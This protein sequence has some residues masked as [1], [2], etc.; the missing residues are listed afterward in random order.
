LPDFARPIV[1]PLIY[2]LLLLDGLVHS[3]G[4]AIIL[5]TVLLRLLML[6]LTLQSLKSSKAMQDLQPQLRELQKKYAK[7]KEKLT[8][9]TMRLYREAGINPAMGC[10]PMLIQIPIFFAIYWAILEV[11]H[12]GGSFAAPFLWL[13]SL[14]SEDPYKILPI[15]AGVT[16]FIQQ[17]MMTPPGG[18]SDPQQKA[19]NNAMQFM[20][21]MIVVFAWSFAS[22]PVLYWVASSVFSAVQQ[23]FITGWGSLPELF[24]FLRP[25]TISSQ[26]PST[27]ADPGAT[28]VRAE[29]QPKRREGGGQDRSS[30]KKTRS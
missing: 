26:A 4:W 12:R 9:E 8:Q 10:L 17:R 7:D 1:E 11:S 5:F 25:K 14:A 16:Q 3:G 21:L 20:P 13:P 24:A 28:E 30:K 2:I 22:G 18:G 15:L 27:R 19:M 6:P 29:G 23:Y